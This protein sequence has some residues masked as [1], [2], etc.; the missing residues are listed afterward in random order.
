MP[1]SVGQIVSLFGVIYGPFVLVA[2]AHILGWLN[3]KLRDWLETLGAARR[4][5]RQP[6][7]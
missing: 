1:L 6:T 4:S 7:D 3:E 2:V 5:Y